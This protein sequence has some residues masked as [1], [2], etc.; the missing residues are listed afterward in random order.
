M[1]AR[2]TTTSRYLLDAA[3]ASFPM[4]CLVTDDVVGAWAGIR[5]LVPMPATFP[6]RRRAN[7]RSATSA[8]GVISITGGK[9]TTYRVMASDVVRAV[10]ARLGRRPPT[11]VTE[12]KPLPGGDFSK[13]ET[14]I[15]R[16]AAEIGDDALAVHLAGAHGTRWP[17]VWEEIQKPGGRAGLAEGLPYT[18]GEFRY[19]VRNEMACTVGDLLIRRTRLAFETRDHGL[20][21]AERVATLLASI[22]GWN[23]DTVRRAIA[24]YEREVAS[25]FTIL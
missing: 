21:C 22:F 13:L 11:G 14:L 3:N 7:M 8:R 12:T 24:A 20:A 5:P 6:A 16:A 17:A 10:F 23:D 4:A 2:R 15:L 9:L 25:V 19:S 1:S 18:I